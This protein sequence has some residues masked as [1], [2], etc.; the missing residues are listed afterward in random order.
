MKNINGVD[1]TG[2]NSIDCYFLVN[3][4]GYIME[5]GD[6]SPEAAK[7]QCAF[8]QLLENANPQLGCTI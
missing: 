8:I 5:I 1:I 4:Q 3:K 6:V 7:F 2:Q